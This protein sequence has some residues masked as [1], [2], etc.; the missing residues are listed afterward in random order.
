M[1]QRAPG[2]V[3]Q[4]V[5]MALILALALQ[6][7]WI[8]HLPPP[9]GNA[10]DLPPPP[11]LNSVRLADF[12]EPI[13]LAQ[14]TNLYLQAFDDQPGI[15]IPFKDLDY[16]RLIAWLTLSLDLDPKSQYPL[17][18][19]ARVYSQV[20]DP[21]RQRQMLDFVYRAFFQDPNRRWPWLADAALTA[22]HQLHDSPLALKYA[23]AIAAKATGSNVPH[24]AQQMP[25]FI[26]ADMGELQSAKVLLGAL[27]ATG[28]I[29]DPHELHFLMGQ[30]QALE[31]KLA[32]ARQIDEKSSEPMR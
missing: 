23:Q 8:R 5:V 24:W 11:T 1:K 2:T 22:K 15:S 12:G 3:P 26:L 17:L 7:L 32:N 6:V 18:L 27:L 21:N 28:T 16:S 14:A 13:A 31:K 29:T 10:Q 30:Y 20:P 25:I 9:R 19:A 4:P